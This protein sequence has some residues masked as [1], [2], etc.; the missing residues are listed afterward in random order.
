MSTE[1]RT[2]RD[3]LIAEVLQGVLQLQDRIAAL[4][5]QI[6]EALNPTVDRMDR[7]AASIRMATDNLIQAGNKHQLSISEYVDQVAVR[8]IQLVSGQAEE[9]INTPPLRTALGETQPPEPAAVQTPAKASSAVFWIIA[10]ALV[11]FAA[12]FLTGRLA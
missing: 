4:P 3:A 7:A 6:N 1:P 12:G 9:R 2:A 10:S 11:A 5:A 8:K